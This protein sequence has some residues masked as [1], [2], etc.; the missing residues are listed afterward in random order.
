[1]RVTARLCVAALLLATASG[2]SV[3]TATPRPS[4]TSSLPAPAERPGTLDAPLDATG[5]EA[6]A[7]LAPDQL[8][9][10]EFDPRTIL[11]ESTGQATS[12]SWRSADGADV[13][14]L[15]INVNSWVELIYASEGEIADIT[16]FSLAGYPAVR[17]GTDESTVCAIYTAIAETQVFTVDMTSRSGVGLCTRAERI[18]QALVAALAARSR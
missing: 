10:A 17:E 5:I 2:C 1:M 11:D 8:A 18:G 16:P 13:V 12:C 9:A 7:V 6:C 3:S 15:S 14:R 4:A